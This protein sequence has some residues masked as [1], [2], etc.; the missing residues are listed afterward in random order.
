MFNHF[1]PF[2]DMIHAQSRAQRSGI[3]F[4]DVFREHENLVFYKNASANITGILET[5]L[6][7]AL[8][9]HSKPSRQK[10]I[11]TLRQVFAQ[12]AKL[13]Q[14]DKDFFLYHMANEKAPFPDKEVSA[15]YRA[16]ADREIMDKNDPS[17]GHSIFTLLMK[18]W[19]PIFLIEISSSNEWF[20]RKPGTKNPAPQYIGTLS[21]IH[22]QWSLMFIE[23]LCLLGYRRPDAKIDI[24]R[25]F[26]PNPCLRMPCSTTLHTSTGKCEPVGIR[27]NEY[28]CECQPQFQWIPPTKNKVGYCRPKPRCID[29]CDKV[30]TLRCDVIGRS[31]VCV[32]RPTH[33]GPTCATLRDP[34]IELSRPELMSGNAACN[35]GRGGRCIGVLGTNT[36]KCACPAGLRGDAN[37]FFP[38]CLAF[39]DRCE[40]TICVHGDCISSRNGQKVY[41]IC[42]DE[43]YGEF[44]QYIRG[45]WAQWSPW[46]QCTPNCGFSEIRR[47]SRTR[48]CLG[49]ACRG[50]EGHFQMETCPVSP[51]PDEILALARQGRP[52]EISELK[53]QL[54]QA[55]TARNVR[56]IE[57]VVKSLMTISCIF[58]V[59]TAL[60]L[61]ASVY[62]M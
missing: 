9:V 49:E 20:S 13:P 1:T 21:K 29:Y 58:S 34:C 43:A 4:D 28:S 35:T 36:Y 16:F 18:A 39:K 10:K 46:S 57:A 26:C 61:V 53:Y 8:L 12:N 55:Q 60:A 24:P 51:C 41:C 30:G 2:E 54:L 38:N 23:E 11:P 17:M 31:E 37:Y 22:D 7:T 44:C 52:E 14:D 5:Y 40:S 62:L 32:C 6:E 47:R 48:G 3:Q 25:G 50:G 59:V 15:L 45:K 56:L 33:M 27:W 19:K 42:T